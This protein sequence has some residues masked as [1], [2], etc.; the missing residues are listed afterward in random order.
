MANASRQSQCAE[1]L[2]RL[3]RISPKAW[4]NRA[5]VK[6]IFASF[7]ARMWSTTS[8]EGQEAYRSGFPL[9]RAVVDLGGARTALVVACVKRCGTGRPHDLPQGGTALFGQADCAVQNF[10]AQAVIAIENARLLSE[11]R[12]ALERQTA[13]AEVLEVINASPGDLRP[14]IRCNS[15]KGDALLRGRYSDSWPM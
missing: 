15:R 7:K 13:T 1:C 2:P 9:R 4:T 12:E 8:T 11:Q 14:G 10:A 5:L 3:P 6:R